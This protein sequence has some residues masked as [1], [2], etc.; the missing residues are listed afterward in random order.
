MPRPVI[1]CDER[2]RYT[3][4]GDR[5]P[6]VSSIAKVCASPDPLIAW[7]FRI[8]RE[9]APD[10]TPW[11][12]R[13][14]AGKRGDSVHKALERLAQHGEVPQP[15]DYPV[16]ERGHVRALLRWYLDFR[17]RFEATEVVVGSRR[18]RFAGRYDVRCLIEGRRIV[19]RLILEET[20]GEREYCPPA[21]LA[22]AEEGLEASVLA[23]C[24]TS[25]AVYPTENFVQLSGYEL[26]SVD[27]GYTP[28]DGQAVLNTSDDGTYR[29][30]WSWSTADDFLAYLAAYNA[31]EGI[32]AQ[33]PA[34]VAR[35]RRAAAREAKARADL[36]LEE[37]ILVWLGQHPRGVGSKAIAE[38]LDLEQRETSTR[39]QAMKKRDEVAVEGR[40][41]VPLRIV[42]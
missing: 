2:H 32:K 5:V 33:D 3:L 7:A 24:K 6:G 16:E 10:E 27:S 14:K 1:E 35:K 29:F 25:K 42:A 8:G 38:A 41:W 23:D 37:R 4:D 19:D 12:T 9:G 30:A 26:G 17:P 20:T 40:K 22:L 28:T 18:H 11:N 36:A 31:R 15:N 34:E 13:K 21:I 39:L